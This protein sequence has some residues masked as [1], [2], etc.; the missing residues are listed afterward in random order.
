LNNES[1]KKW[2]RSCIGNIKNSA[3]SGERS[4]LASRSSPGA[5]GPLPGRNRIQD[6][7]QRDLSRAA[8]CRKIKARQRSRRTNIKY[9][10]ANTK[11]FFLR[12]NGRK[13]KKHI[14]ILQTEDGLAIRHEDK[15]KEIERHFGEMLGTK[16]A[17]SASL[18][19]ITLPST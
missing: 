12:A 19:L 1:S 4:L 14:Q 10:D 5:E 15:A 2:E 6:K 13:R 17:K 16:K 3:C 7:T 11:L 8:H 9:G 18:S